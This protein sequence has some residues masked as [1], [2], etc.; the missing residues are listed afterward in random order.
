MEETDN[1]I[2]YNLIPVQTYQV[3]DD[4]Y[5]PVPYYLTQYDD[6]LTINNSFPKNSTFRITDLYSDGNSV[7]GLLANYEDKVTLQNAHSDIHMRGSVFK[8]TTNSSRKENSEPMMNAN[9]FELRN[10]FPLTTA[11]LAT[12][13]HFILPRKI[14][15]IVNKKLVIADDGMVPDSN[16]CNVDRFVFF[17]L[18]SEISETIDVGTSFTTQASVSSNMFYTF[19]PLFDAP[20]Y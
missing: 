15:G 19:D 2:F 13:K 5:Y 6:K 16:D 10:S 14:V 3:D 9:H 17:D 1:G 12:A 7:Y 4:A 11:D 20:Q 18:A 8:L